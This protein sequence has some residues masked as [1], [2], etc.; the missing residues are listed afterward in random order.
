MATHGNARHLVA[1]WK[2]MDGNVT[3]M[4]CT[5]QQE[6]GMDG[7]VGQCMAMGGNASPCH[8]KPCHAVACYAMA[9]HAM[10]C[11]AMACY[12][13]TWTAMKGNGRQW[14]AMGGNA[15]KEMGGNLEWPFPDDGEDF[16]GNCATAE[17]AQL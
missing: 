14:K 5:G 13:M 1:M 16:S 7:H 8:C 4:G 2:A 15:D 10:A 12:S 11:P 3:A 9:R 6:T 17:A